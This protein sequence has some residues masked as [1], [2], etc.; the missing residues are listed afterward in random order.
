MIS[1]NLILKYRSYV[2][3]VTE[4]NP[5][6]SLLSKKHDNEK[7]EVRHLLENIIDNEKNGLVGT[8]K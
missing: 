3:S 4:A 8:V 2:Q 1:S 7:S 6:V 5:T